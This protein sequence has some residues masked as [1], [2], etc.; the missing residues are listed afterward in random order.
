[1][2]IRFLR[3][4]LPHLLGPNAGT[5][6]YSR[7]PVCLKLLHA[8][9]LGLPFTATCKAQDT[10]LASGVVQ[11]LGCQLAWGFRTTGLLLLYLRQAALKCAV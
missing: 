9:W 2:Q 10:L 5:T 11:H 6:F 8:A 4:S 7:L 1:M 3:S